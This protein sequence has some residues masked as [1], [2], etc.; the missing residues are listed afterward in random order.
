MPDRMG[1]NV[2]G[3]PD[4]ERI[5]RINLNQLILRPLCQVLELRERDDAASLTIDLG[6]V[7]SVVEDLIE[8]LGGLSEG[9]TIIIAGV[10]R[11]EDGRRVRL[12][13]PAESQP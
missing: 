4:T 12:T 5:L 11:L 13:E 10:R 1:A 3:Q 9:D 6:V 2:V 8:V 7:E